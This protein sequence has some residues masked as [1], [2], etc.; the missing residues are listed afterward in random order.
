VF[1]PDNRRLA[2]GWSDG[3]IRMHD[4][5]DAPGRRLFAIT[6][7]R[8]RLRS[9]CFDKAGRMLLSAADDHKVRIVH[10]ADGQA[11]VTFDAGAPCVEAG[12]GAGDREVLCV[13]ADA[14]HLF[15]VEPRARAAQA[16]PRQMTAEERRRLGL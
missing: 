3:A 15:P 7:H 10:S 8:L 11:K 5:H 1:S 13:C 16:C 2:T 9:L 12:F 4:C 6:P 14:V